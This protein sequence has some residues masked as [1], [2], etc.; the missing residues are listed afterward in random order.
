MNDCTFQAEN[1]PWTCTDCGWIYPRP[2]A[3]P[4]RR[5][6]HKSPQGKAGRIANLTHA[7]YEHHDSCYP[8]RTTKDLSRLIT[9]CKFCDDYYSHLPDRCNATLP[10]SDTP[11][12]PSGCNGRRQ[13]LKSLSSVGFRECPKWGTQQ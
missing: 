11:R 12:F 6:C 13:W 4:P 10:D 3:K 2:S 8:L 7:A 1:A 5:D 9:I